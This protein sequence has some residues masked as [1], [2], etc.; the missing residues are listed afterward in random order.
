MEGEVIGVDNQIFSDTSGGGNI[1]L[2]F[3]IPSNDVRFLLEQVVQYGKPRL[4]WV[5]MRLQTVTPRM[6]GALG[7]TVEGGAIVAEVVADGPAA[8]AGLHVGDI[9]QGVGDEHVTNSRTVDRA[10]VPSIGKTL[11]L[12]VWR[13]GKTGIIPV[14]VKEYPQET[15]T[16]YKNEKVTDVVFA[17]ISDSGMIVADLTDE[18]R[19]RFHL[20]R[21][22]TGP[23]VT[24][25]VDNTVASAAGLQPGDV[26][27]K[28]QLEDVHSLSQMAERLK[29]LSNK[30]QRDAL[31]LVGRAGDT[32]WLTLPLRL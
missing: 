27:L 10:I 9:V 8:E 14:A 5:G 12:R 23:V 4:G 13:D 11:Q 22:I 26:I 15:W 25:V 20:E 31:F 16:S 32:T 2:G 17:K 3:A 28:V 7:L 18:L 21:Q 24:Q 6:A 30:G 29:A 19:A 1:G